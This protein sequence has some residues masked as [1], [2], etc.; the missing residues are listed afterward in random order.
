M[1]TRITLWILILGLLFSQPVWAADTYVLDQDHT[2]V[3]FKIRH[4]F[5]WV[6]GTFNEFEGSFVYDPDNPEVWTADA[7]IQTASIDTRV[8]ERDNHLRTADFF[9]V[10]KYPT[11]TFKSTKVT[12]VTPA[13]AKLHGVLSLHGVEKPVIMDLEIFG[14]GPDAWGN[15]LAGFSASTKINRKDFGLTWNEILETGQLLVGE[16]V[17]IT[18]EVEGMLQE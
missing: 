10:E 4:V 11:M 17:L 1:R 13:G 16:D 14:T 12:D 3:G 5:S 2:T 7:T 9:D 6:L 8:K 18:I 15:T